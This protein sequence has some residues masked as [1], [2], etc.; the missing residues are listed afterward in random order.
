MQAKF[1]TVQSP[2]AYLGARWDELVEKSS[3]SGRLMSCVCV[4]GRH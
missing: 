2:R 3:S 4:W 1:F